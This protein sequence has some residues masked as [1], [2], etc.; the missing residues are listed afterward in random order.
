VHRSDLAER[1]PRRRA[2]AE[3]VDGVFAG[4]RVILAQTITLLESTLARDRDL[5]E[6]ILERL[7]PATGKSVRVGITGVPGV[8]KSTFIDALGT[9]LTETRGEKVAVLAV[10]PSS[11]LS[12]GSI[13]GD[14]TRMPRLALNE[15]AFIRPSP[16]RGALGGVAQRTREAILVCEAAGYQNILVETVGVGQ[17]ETLVAT[18]VDFFLLLMLP[19]AGDE[20][21]G[22]KRGIIELADLIAINKADGDNR[23]RAE[24]AQR[25]FTRALA[26][27]PPPPSGWPA[28][29]ITCSAAQNKGVPET[30]DIVRQYREH[31][32]A[33]GYFDHRR[34][35]QD[36]EWIHQL[37]AE[38]LRERFLGDSA[39]QQKMTEL[40]RAVAEGRMTSFRAARELLSAASQSST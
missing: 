27:F 20:L 24:F 2:V 13:L 38:A 5:A 11:A 15:R 32:V 9:H 1:R 3:Y 35:R 30:W 14:K 33:S 18:M 28:R 21:Q 19:G 29:V 26:L 10:D 8:G 40:E 6:Q 16:S 34:R 39:V 25:E 7:L 12:G 36:R 31:T 22:I 4:N 17:S 37:V 23:A